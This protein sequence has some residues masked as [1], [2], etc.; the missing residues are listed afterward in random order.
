MFPTLFDVSHRGSIYFKT[1]DVMTMSFWMN[2]CWRHEQRATHI[3]YMQ[4]RETILGVSNLYRKF[5]K[6]WVGSLCDSELI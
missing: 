2:R 3:A 1:R 4:E 5:W 6:V